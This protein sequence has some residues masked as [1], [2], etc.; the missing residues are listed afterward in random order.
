[1]YDYSGVVPLVEVMR[2]GRVESVHYG[3]VAAVDARGRLIA[4]AGDPNLVAYLRS[5]AKPFQL[6][7]FVEAGGADHF[8]LSDRELAVMAASHSGEPRHVEAVLGILNKIGLDESALQCGTHWPFSEESTRLLRA[9]G[10]EPT[11]A[12]NNCS[13]KHSG[14]LACAVYRG[15]STHNY[16]DLDHPVQQ[17]ILHTLAEMSD[18]DPGEIGVGVDGCSVPCFAISLRACALAFARL[19]DPSAQPG[20]R[21]DAAR[22]IARAMSS[23]PEMVAGEGRLDTNLMRALR[24]DAVSKGGAEGYQGLGLVSRGL[25]VA[26]KI[27]DG[28]NE[29][30]CGPVAIETLRQ[31]GAIDDAALAE[32]QKRH[33]W[34]VENHRALLVGEVRPVFNL[35]F[36]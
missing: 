21:R 17:S 14:M 5:T 32:M 3:A 12:Y 34:I 36:V 6:L 29:R 30:G 1:M 25:G 15:L 24:G 20:P 8:G 13:G 23:Y 22:R 18:L 35:A 16:L 27:I 26:A 19:A 28:N 4:H 9:S 7:P 10:R 11:P 33:R 2:G 31:L